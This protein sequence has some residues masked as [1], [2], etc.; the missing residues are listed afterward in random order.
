LESRQDHNDHKD[1]REIYRA[2]AAGV[3]SS[4]LAYRHDGPIQEP[5]L[6][7]PDAIAGALGLSIATGFDELA[8]MLPAPLR[9]IRWIGP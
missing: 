4:S 2:I 6:W 8:R 3:G 1:R 7:L 9:E 5:L